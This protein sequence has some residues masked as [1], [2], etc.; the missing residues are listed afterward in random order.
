MMTASTGARGTGDSRMAGPQEPADLRAQLAGRLRAARE[1][2]AA[3]ARRGRAGR[4]VLGLHA[5]RMDGLVRDIAEAAGRQAP[6]AAVVCAVGGYGRRALCLHSDVD[7]LIVTAGPIDTAAERFINALLQ[8]LWDLRLSVGQHV[9]ELA[10]LDEVEV[11]NPELLLALLDLRYVAGDVPLYEEVVARLDAGRQARLPH[12]LAALLNL[13][14]VRHA[15]FNHTIYQLEPDVKDAPGALRD[16][17]ALRLLRLLRPEAFQGDAVALGGRALDAEDF[18]F[19]VRSVLHATS[20][21]NSNLLTHAL[22]EVVAEAIGSDGASAQQRVE[23]LMSDY[24]RWARPV[25]RSLARSRAALAPAAGQIAPRALGRYLEI[26]DDGVR[27][28]DPDRMAAMP[29]MW[30]EAFRIALVEGCGLSEQART[31][32]EENVGRYTAGRLRRH[33]GGPPAAARPARAPPGALRQA[34]GNARQRAARLHLPGVRAGF[35]PA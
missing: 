33:R 10:D 12:S 14:D 8:P 19:R 3:D 30:L 5:D 9:R 4:E 6:I 7:I 18:L 34:L 31:C 32:I 15:R 16:L 21:R 26:A 13:T 11:D 2:Y 23:A 22:Q 24:F 27:F 1:A 17:D 35:S 28:V 20:G 29:A 25:A